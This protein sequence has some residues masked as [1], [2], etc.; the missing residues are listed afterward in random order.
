MLGVV[1]HI[2]THKELKGFM[3]EGAPGDIIIIWESRGAALFL[4]DKFFI[5]S[6][7]LHTIASIK[8][9]TTKGWNTVKLIWCEVGIFLKKIL[10]ILC[11]FNTTVYFPSSSSWWCF[12]Q[13]D[14]CYLRQSKKLTFVPCFGTSLTLFVWQSK[15]L[16]SITTT[17]IECCCK[18]RPEEA[19]LLKRK[20]QDEVSH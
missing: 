4:T 15:H 1:S 7:M 8:N 19:W 11:T 6:M 14:L 16:R 3:V 5:Q 18:R 20:D 10:N 12:T 17:V 9:Q 2:W 13:R